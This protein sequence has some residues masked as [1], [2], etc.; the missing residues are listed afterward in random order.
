MIIIHAVQKLMNISRLK[1]A[2]FISEPADQQELHSWYAKLVSTTFRGK[3][4]VMYVH[5]PSLVVI[6]TRGKTITGTMPEFC[7]RLKAFLNRNHFDEAFANREMEMIRQGYVISKTNSK[8]MIG[9]MN[10]ITENIEYRCSTFIDFESID[11]DDIED[12]FMEWLVYDKTK[13][14]YLRRTSDYWREKR[15]IN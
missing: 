6:L 14:Y 11:M 8:S 7:N 10:A 3:L 9:S 1:P 15:L 4:L 13:P 12:A 2:L 5:Q